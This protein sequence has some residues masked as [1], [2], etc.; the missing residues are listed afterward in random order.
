MKSTIIEKPTECGG[1]VCC[2]LLKEKRTRIKNN[3]KGTNDYGNA[4]DV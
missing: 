1:R 3:K 2:A 4:K